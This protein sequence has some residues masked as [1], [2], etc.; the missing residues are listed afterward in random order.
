MPIFNKLFIAVFVAVY[1]S[2]L[3]YSRQVHSSTE[4]NEQLTS[5]MMIYMF[6][7]GFAR[8]VAGIWDVCSSRSESRLTRVISNSCIVRIDVREAGFQ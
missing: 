6:N 1:V 2:V 8:N 5:H 7:R 3:D 4:E